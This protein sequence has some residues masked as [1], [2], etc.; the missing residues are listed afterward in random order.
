[1]QKER[2]RKREGRGKRENVAVRTAASGEITRAGVCTGYPRDARFSYINGCHCK[3]ARHRHR[4]R[5]AARPGQRRRRRRPPR[6]LRHSRLRRVAKLAADGTTAREGVRE[7]ETKKES[8]RI[9]TRARLTSAERP[10]RIS[11]TKSEDDNECREREKEAQ[12]YIN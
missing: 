11:S 3:S 6:A 4:R 7:R 2:E 9:K 8:E 5:H 12:F 10:A 1:M